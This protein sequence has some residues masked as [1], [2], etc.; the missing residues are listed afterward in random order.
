MGLKKVG[1]GVPW[2]S[3]TL[4]IQPCG[5][6]LLEGNEGRPARDSECMKNCQ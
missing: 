1:K 3:R 6:L 4:C 5:L 2:T